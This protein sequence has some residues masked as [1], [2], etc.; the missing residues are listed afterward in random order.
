MADE[1]EPT[2]FSDVDS[3]VAPSYFI[4]YL[5]AARK[6]SAIAQA[7]E[8][9]IEHLHLARCQRVLD[10]GCGTGEDAIA[11]SS[12]VGHEGGVVGADSSRAMISEGK[13]RHGHLPGVCFQVGDAQRLPFASE[14]FDSCRTER[15]LQHLADPD[16]AVVEMARVLRKGGHLAL[17]EPDWEALVIEGADAGLSRT[18]LSRHI[19]LHSQ[20]RM[21]R[22][23]RGLLTA[24]G[25]DDVRLA[26][27]MVLH[28]DLDT[29][30]RAFGI[31]RAVVGA[32]S[33]ASI[34]QAEADRWLADLER[35]DGE[36]RFSVA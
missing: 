23:L 1:A 6:T 30:N 15:T 28:T 25:F 12:I 10:V 8:W 27:G 35:A 24:N 20:P 13:R 14:T 4:Q 32:V 11:I 34:S 21:G 26:A 17:V 18:I 36:G 5:D 33:A 29:S 3:S 31:V 22:R 16:T 2:G 7:K 19:E 9:S